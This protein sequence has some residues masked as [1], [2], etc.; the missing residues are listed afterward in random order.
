MY[1]KRYRRESMDL[2]KSPGIWNVTDGSH[3][4]IWEEVQ[5]KVKGSDIT[6]Q[7]K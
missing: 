4:G 6:V 5:L 1:L 7:L 3:L 2:T